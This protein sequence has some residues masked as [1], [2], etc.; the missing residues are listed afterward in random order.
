[1]QAYGG[2]EVEG[3]PG[4]ECAGTGLCAEVVAFPKVNFAGE[5][6][7]DLRDDKFEVELGDNG[8]GMRLGLTDE[9]MDK[10]FSRLRLAATRFRF[11]GID[12]GVPLEG[13]LVVVGGAKITSS[14]GF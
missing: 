14:S 10:R 11:E 13:E 9:P 12:V 6:G 2:G 1:M 4:D 5:G 7:G 3:L 8:G